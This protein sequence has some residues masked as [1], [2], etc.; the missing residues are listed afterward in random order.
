MANY[1][2]LGLNNVVLD[3]QYINNKEC[4]NDEGEFV[5][6]LGIDRLVELTGHA[7]WVRCSFNTVGN[8]RCHASDTKPP[9]RLNYPKR[10]YHYD[11]TLDG[12]VEPP[13]PDWPTW[14]LDESTGL[15]A[16]PSPYPTDG[17]RYK[18]SNDEVA[19]VQMT[20]EEYYV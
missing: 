2:K 6:Q 7:T 16:A 5:D 4:M 11:A 18:W 19:W 15:R 3:V 20:Q 10:G 8:K 13:N 12:F 17:A 14:V 1:A 9:F